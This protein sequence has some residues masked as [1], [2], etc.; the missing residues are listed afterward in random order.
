MCASSRLGLPRIMKQDFAK[1]AISP[2]L[3]VYPRQSGPTVNKPK[4]HFSQVA[5]PS[6]C[7]NWAHRQWQALVLPFKLTVSGCSLK[8]HCLCCFVKSHKKMSLAVTQKQS[9]Q[10]CRLQNSVQTPPVY[11]S[12]GTQVRCTWVCLF[13]G[14]VVWQSAALF[15]LHTPKNVHVSALE[16]A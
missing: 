14:I 7:I 13:V 2:I 12:W 9:L 11:A 5:S 8:V 6:C 4:R 15:H 3:T 10:T 16:R 1:T